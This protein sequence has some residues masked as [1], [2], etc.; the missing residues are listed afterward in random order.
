MENRRLFLFLALSLVVMMLWQA[1]E[2]DYGPKP[3]A[4][5][6]SSQTESSFPAIPDN[7]GVPSAPVTATDVPSAVVST[8]ATIPGIAAP[9]VQN[10]GQRI[11][12]RTDL[13]S[14]EI[15][16]IGGD[17]QVVELLKYPQAQSTPDKPVRLLDNQLQSYFVAQSGLLAG[18]A[19]APDHYA[20][21]NALQNDYQLQGGS[22]EIRVP[23]TWTGKQG[24]SVTKT[25]VFKRNSYVIA[26]EYQVNN[27]SGQPWNG[28]LYRQLQR[29]LP[30]SSGDSK[31][32]YTYTGGVVSTEANRY[33]KVKLEDMASWKAEESY[34]KGGWAAMI[35]HYFLSAW[36]ANENELNHYY[37][38]VVSDT[39][40][41]LGMS[42]AEAVVPAGT[43]QQFSTRLFVGPKEQHR[44]EDVSPNL[45][46]TVDYGFLTIIA[47]PL[48]WLL[49]NIFKLVQNWGWS[50]ILL[51]LLIKLVF[52][53]LTEASYRS[54]ANM[55]RLQPKITQLRERYASDRQRMSQAMMDLYKKEKIN[56][57]GGC[58]PML[59]QIPVFIAL[60]WVLLESVEMRQAPFI[61]WLT[62]LS[63]KDPYYVLPV[64]MGASM[65]VQQKLQPAAFADPIHQK[66]MMALPFVFTLFFAFFPSGLVLYWTVN[67]V[68]SIA[69]QWHIT[70][71]IEAKAA[72]K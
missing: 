52:F 55:R 13:L 26:V 5:T 40:Y 27:Q 35:Q 62:D 29:T 46:L 60:Y 70:R 32:I 18:A 72:K 25:L 10:S 44:L 54:M 23:L 12:V 39:R 33:E 50:I 14:V 49:E 8:P 66:I 38:N 6:N 71:Q 31:F 48:F 57:M 17:V 56:P 65:F 34:A 19:E 45:K 9:V 67:N 63:A 61:G 51:T 28:R 3:I 24:I 11:T 7:R 64:L 4:A 59:V 68:L 37:S 16:T 36:L 20:V 2:Q 47:Q 1:W 21:Y 43:S 69:Q 15:N 30:G 22:D 42:T 41:V 58:L 53:K